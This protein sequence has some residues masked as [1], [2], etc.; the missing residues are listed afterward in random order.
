MV[1]LGCMAQKGDAVMTICDI[2]RLAG[3]SV[4]T[5]SRVINHKGYVKAETREKIEKLIQEY[6]YRPNA[7]ARSLIRSDTSM[8]A[9]IMPGRMAPFFSDILD[10]IE[11]KADES[12]YRALFYNTYEDSVR[13]L[14]AVEQAIEHR[15]VGIL[16]LPVIGTQGKTLRLLQE[17]EQ[18]GIPVVL[19]DRE[20]PGGDFDQVMLDNRAVVYE[21]VQLLIERGHRRIGMITCP[22]VTAQGRTRLEGYL[23]CLSAYKIQPNEEYIYRGDFREDSA[24]HACEHFYAL[25]TPPTAIL[26]T[27]SSGILGCIRYMN[28]HRLCIGKDV[29]LVGFDD[30][31]MLNTI[32]YQITVMDRR[33]REMGEAAYELLL[34]R[35]HSRKARQRH[36]SYFVETDMLVRGSECCDGVTGKAVSV[37]SGGVMVTERPVSSAGTAEETFA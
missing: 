22:E 2:A 5:V 9:V 33:K 36:K 29:G 8:I 31:A 6:N 37:R 18:E 7:V 21:G 17:A 19:L 4:T 11:Q 28:E 1:V 30:I 14:R 26:A 10:A 20:I 13:E 25:E 3:V 34:E 27:C 32:G 12:G 23:S 15:V 35:L 24:Y 16:M